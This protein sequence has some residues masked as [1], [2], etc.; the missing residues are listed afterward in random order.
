M[1]WRI[2]VEIRLRSLV[3]SVMLEIHVILFA[4]HI[5]DETIDDIVIA[6]TIV[7][8]SAITAQIVSNKWFIE[9]FQ[10]SS[11]IIINDHHLKVLVV[12]T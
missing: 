8:N 3:L 2:C 11:E 1:T 12:I 7:T 10:Y 9:F 5:K 6:R 4:H